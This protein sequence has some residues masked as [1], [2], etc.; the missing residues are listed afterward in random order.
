MSF[1]GDIER[2]TAAVD[3]RSRRVLREFGI[4]AKRRMEDITPVRTGEMKAGWGFTERRDGIDIYNVAPHAKWVDQGSDKQ[5]PQ[6]IIERTLMNSDQI[7]AVAIER[8]GGR[9]IT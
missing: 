4:E 9:K 3:T 5:P 8:A 7:L 1:S 6:R 2:F